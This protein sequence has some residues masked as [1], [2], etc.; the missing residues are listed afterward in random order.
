MKSNITSIYIQVTEVCV[1]SSMYIYVYVYIFL[2]RTLG[3]NLPDDEYMKMW[4]S[5]KYEKEDDRM[6]AAQS[7]LIMSQSKCGE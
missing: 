6:Y 1:T 2:K 7:D 5:V 3:F 4:E